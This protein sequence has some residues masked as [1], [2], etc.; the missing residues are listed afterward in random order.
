MKPSPFEYLAPTGEDEAVGILAEHGDEAKVLA[1][2]Q[3][4]VPLLSLR[5]AHPSVLVDLAGVPGL[6]HVRIED[7]TLVVGAMATQRAVEELPGLTERCPMIA[8]AVGQIGHVAIRN[9]GTVGGSVAHADPAAEWPALVVALDAEVD[10]VGPGGARTIGAANLF[11]T[12]FT[13]SLE[14]DEIVRELRVPLPNGGR[15]GSTFVELARRHGDFAIAGVAA[16]LSL[17]DAGRVTD[18]RVGLTGL[19]DTPARGRAAESVLAGQ[20]PTDDAIAAAAAAVDEDIDPADDVHAS[21][22]YRRKVAAVLTRRALTT[23]RERA[24]RGDA[25]A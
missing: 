4:L 22:D 9:R 15:T 24:R 18:A 11:R 10:V 19:R 23:A 8:E 25:S 6:D 20:E 1:G 7:D 12:Y 2:G 14:P 21:A 13:T 3:S 16:S 5:L 17:D